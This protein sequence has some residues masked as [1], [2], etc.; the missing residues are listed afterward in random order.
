M[1]TFSEELEVFQAHRQEWLRTNAGKFVAIQHNVIEGFFDTYGDALR[2]GL[3][4]FGVGKNFLIKQV[5]TT[6][7][8]YVVS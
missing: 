5:W 4:R 8:V 2:A 6:E 7:P 3:K 1:L